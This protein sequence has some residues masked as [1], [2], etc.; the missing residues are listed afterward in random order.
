MAR[1]FFN[2]VEDGH[3]VDVIGADYPDAQMARMEAVRFVGQVLKEEP[4][5]VWNGAE[6]RIEATDVWDTVLFTI[7]IAGVDAEALEQH[8]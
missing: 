8:R 1:Y 7:L 5:R 2:I 3:K 4:E 6:I